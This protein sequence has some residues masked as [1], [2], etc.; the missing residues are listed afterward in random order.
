MQDPP[1][2]IAAAV[3]RIA[4]RHELCRAA[5]GA[6]AFRGDADP[7]DPLLQRPPFGEARADRLAQVRYVYGASV[8]DAGEKLTFDLFYVKNQGLLF[9]MMI[10]LQTVEVVLFRR[11]SR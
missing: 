4:R 7:R 8:Q 10:L 11:G 6:P 5:T 1:G 9:D 3:Q 2:R